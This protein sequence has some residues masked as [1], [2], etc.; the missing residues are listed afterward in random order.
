LLISDTTTGNYFLRTAFYNAGITSIPGNL[1]SAIT[2]IDSYFLSSAFNGSGITSVPSTLI[3]AVVLNQVVT[4]DGYLQN[5]FANCASLISVPTGL[6]P[7]GTGL[8][9]ANKFLSGT[10]SNSGITSVPADFL[11]NITTVGQR[12]CENIFQNCTAL[13]T[14][15]RGF[16][17]GVTAVAAYYLL[18]AFSGCTKLNEVH[19]TY[20]NKNSKSS[21]LSKTLENVASEA[22]PK[23]TLYIH[24]TGG[25][26]SPVSSS[27]ALKVSNENVELIK[28][29][30]SLVQSYK[31]STLWG[32]A[33]SGAIDEDKFVA[34]E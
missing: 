7:S 13:T 9:V 17:S 25:V 4:K 11:S 29:D 14:V 27:V 32:S 34:L 22:S 31:D 1:L 5:T 8:T 30:G 21:F 12:F 19:L 28:V 6:V 18:T 10:F 26:L 15:N 16:A 2:G 23:L 24:G 33:S 20:V 3:P